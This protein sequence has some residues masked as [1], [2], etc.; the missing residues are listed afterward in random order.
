MAFARAVM[1]TRLGSRKKTIR[2]TAVRMVSRTMSSAR[3]VKPRAYMRTT[4]QSAIVARVIAL[5][6]AKI[7]A[8]TDSSD[9]TF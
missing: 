1:L 9:E 8:F 5:S 3:T 2:G 7:H 6:V 4:S